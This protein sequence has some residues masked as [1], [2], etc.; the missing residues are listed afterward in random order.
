MNDA[1]DVGDDMVAGDDGCGGDDDSYGGGDDGNE[2]DV[3]FCQHY[4][5]ERKSTFFTVFGEILPL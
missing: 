1:V 3:N 5:V 4:V 2:D